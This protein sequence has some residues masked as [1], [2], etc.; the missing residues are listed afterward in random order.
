MQNAGLEESQVGIKTAE[1]NRNNFRY[2]DDATLMAD[3]E[4]E[5]PTL[6]PSDTKSR[7]TGKDPDSEKD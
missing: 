7:L 4:A 6:W 3:A 2:A 5:A 1:K